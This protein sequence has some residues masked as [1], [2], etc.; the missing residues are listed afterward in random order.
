MKI[1]PHEIDLKAFESYLLNMGAE[2]LPPTNQYELFRFKGLETGIIYTTGKVNSNY[3]WEAIAAFQTGNSQWKGRP[4]P[5]IRRGSYRRQ[6]KSLLAR[7]GRNCF[8]CGKDMGDD[9]TVE[10][11][12]SLAAKGPNT[13]ANMVLC[14]ESCNQNAHNLPAAEKVRM[15][16]QN[17]L[18]TE[19]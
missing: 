15:A 18:K 19:L 1:R 10:H 6:K 3:V 7:D 8:Y 5:T 2:V 17:R 11:L 12:V 16:I 4:E 9:I 13:L 14:H